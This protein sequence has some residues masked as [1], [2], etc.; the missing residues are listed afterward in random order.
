MTIHILHVGTANLNRLMICGA[1]RDTFRECG[2]EAVSEA[3][4]RSAPTI[5]EGETFLF[6]HAPSLLIVER[7][8]PGSVDFIRSL[9]A[10]EMFRMLPVLV[11]GDGSEADGEA[12]AAGAESV[13]TAPVSDETMLLVL[14]PLIRNRALTEELIGKVMRLQDDSLKNFI[15]LDLVKRY[16]SRTVWDIANT[17]AEEQTILIPEKEEEVT[18]V[19]GDIAG[20]TRL[21]QYLKPKDVI[22]LLNEAYQ[23][24]TR[25]IYDRGGDI[26]KFIGDA[27]LAV[28]TQP[29]QAVL[30]AL[31]IQVDMIRLAEDRKARDLPP[32]SFR[33]G[34]HTGPVIRGNVGGDIRS[35]NT[36]IGDTVN[37]AARLESVAPPGEV[38]VSE[39]TLG[40]TAISVPESYR[41]TE[42]VKGKDEPLVAYNIFRYARETGKL[43]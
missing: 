16:I 25:T 13:L 10:D 12:Y 34:V 40:R 2:Q 17:Y 41:I 4:I 43:L 14:K 18:I 1:V 9:K 5:E 32:F 31:R 36:L 15:L 30:A 37:T 33:I 24:V 19:Y 7:P 29:L 26:D 22:S 6:E 8:V 21:A 27:F 28:F 11:L 23:A 38:L 39:R 35:D 20:F 3:E 42:M